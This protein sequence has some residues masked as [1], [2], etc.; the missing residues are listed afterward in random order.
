MVIA[1]IGYYR[2]LL[3]CAGHSLRH[4]TCRMANL[5]QQCRASVFL[6]CFCFNW[7]E[8]TYYA[9]LLSGVQQSDPVIHIHIYTYIIYI[10]ILFQILFP[11][12]LLQDIE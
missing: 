5:T 12:R 4:V 1:T 11:Y 3:L 9:A 10:Y 7:V 2:R 6:F 8:L